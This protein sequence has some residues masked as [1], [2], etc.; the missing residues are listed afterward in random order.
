MQVRRQGAARERHV[1]GLDPVVR[2][3]GPPQESRPGPSVQLDQF[4]GGLPDR[5]AAQQPQLRRREPVHPGGR[6][7]AA[8]L[9]ALGEPLVPGG[10]GRRDGCQVRE[11]ADRCL[12]HGDV[13]AARLVPYRA[14]RVVQ[15]VLVELDA[16]RGDAAVE[17]P[18]L[19]VPTTRAAPGRCGHGRSSIG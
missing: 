4:L 19:L 7:V 17:Q 10:V 16:Q 12:Q 14:E 18:A 2:H 5:V 15:P 8:V 11:L 9:Q 13:G 1:D 6:R 3:R